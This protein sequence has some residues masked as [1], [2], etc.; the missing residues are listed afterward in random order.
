MYVTYIT[1]YLYFD[2]FSIEGYVTYYGSV[3]YEINK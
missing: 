2:L 3:E 1:L